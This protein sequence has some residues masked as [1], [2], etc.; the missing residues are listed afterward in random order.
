MLLHPN[1]AATSGKSIPTSQLNKV[2]KYGD[3]KSEAAVVARYQDL[4]AAFP[5]VTLHGW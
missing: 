3:V 1:L 2:R 5:A 4:K